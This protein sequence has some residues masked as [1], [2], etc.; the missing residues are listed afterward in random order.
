M[1]HLRFQIRFHVTVSTAKLLLLTFDIVLH[2]LEVSTISA[3]SNQTILIQ[4]ELTVDV[5]ILRTMTIAKLRIRYDCNPVGIGKC[6]NRASSHAWTS[7]TNNLVTLWDGM[8]LVQFK[9]P[10]VIFAG[11]SFTDRI[12]AVPRVCKHAYSEFDIRFPFY[13]M[14][15]Y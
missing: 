2:P 5:E 15:M 14:R 7:K 8:A 3:V 11:F 1:D 6:N 13:D 12:F 9:S 4:N 10:S